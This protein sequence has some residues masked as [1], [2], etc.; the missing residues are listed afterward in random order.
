MLSNKQYNSIF[1]SVKVLP[2]KKLDKECSVFLVKNV[3]QA[4]HNP[5]GSIQKNY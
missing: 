1:V 3:F 5:T 2:D 4:T